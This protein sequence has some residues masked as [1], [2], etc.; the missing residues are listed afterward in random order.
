MLKNEGLAISLILFFFVLFDRNIFSYTQ[1]KSII[2]IPLL[3]YIIIWKIPLL[4]H[5]ISNDLMS[6]GL[7]SRLL[8]RLNDPGQIKLIIKYFVRYCDLCSVFFVLNF[9]RKDVD[10]KNYKFVLFFVLSYLSILFLIYLSTPADLNWHLYTSVKR[11]LLPVLLV[12]FGTILFSFRP[13]SDHI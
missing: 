6:E 10:F 9:F 12:M 5:H 1:K 4:S 11:A 7:I 8:L 3:F 2:L 13:G